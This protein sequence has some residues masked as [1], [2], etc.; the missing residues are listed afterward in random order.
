MP[1]PEW[2]LDG[3]QDA[4]AFLAAAN[5][6]ADQHGRVGMEP[7][8]DILIPNWHD[9]MIL[10]NDYRAYGSEPPEDYVAKGEAE[11]E[12]FLYVCLLSSF[13]EFG[14]LFRDTWRQVRYFWRPNHTSSAFTIQIFNLMNHKFLHLEATNDFMGAIGQEDLFRDP[15]TAV[16]DRDRQGYGITW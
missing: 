3:Q 6:K 16:T 11:I 5:V 14:D 4:R 2:F 9:H 12:K 1:G 10:E 15:H 7:E 13:P 8:A